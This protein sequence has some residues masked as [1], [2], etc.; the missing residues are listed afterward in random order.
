MK[1]CGKVAKII[2]II[3]LMLSFFCVEQVFADADIVTKDEASDWWKGGLGFWN[4]VTKQDEIKQKDVL[5]DVV[6]TIKVLGNALFIIA[7]IW[8]GIRYMAGSADGKKDIKEGL[9]GLVVA[10]LIFYGG[11]T[12]YD[13]FV[14]NNDLVFI[15]E[16][17]EATITNIYDSVIYVLR[18]IAVAVILYIGVK[19]LLA[20]AEGRAELKGKSIPLFVGMAF[21]FG[22]LTVLNFIRLALAE[23]LRLV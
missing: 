12:L 11:S 2:T 3:V 9:L 18:Y 23:I 5:T 20:G 22:T 4:E 15:K 1:V 13:V 21:A 17:E 6:D 16:S 19:Y 14:E 8:M 10:V 7:G